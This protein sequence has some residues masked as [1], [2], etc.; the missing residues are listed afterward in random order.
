LHLREPQEID[1]TRAMTLGMLSS[2]VT[3]RASARLGDEQCRNC[4]YYLEDTA[5]ISYCR[6]PE[7][8]MLV[9]ADWSCVWWEP[10]SEA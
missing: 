3:L 4:R 9:G 5:D 8:R 1:E 10:A 6:H 7:L 2:D